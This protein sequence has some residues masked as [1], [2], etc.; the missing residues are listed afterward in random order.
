MKLHASVLGSSLHSTFSVGRSMFD[1]HLLPIGFRVQG[2][3]RFQV[4]GF[5]CQSGCFADSSHGTPL[6]SR[7]SLIGCAARHVSRLSVACHGVAIPHYRGTGSLLAATHP[8]NPK[9]AA[10]PQPIGAVSAMMRLAALWARG[11]AYE[12]H[13]AFSPPRRHG[14]DHGNGW[15]LA[16][17]AFFISVKL[18]ENPW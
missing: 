15:L 17:D 9:R 5:R 11:G 3:E 2:R 13:H 16:Q 6:G 7:C 4:S 1:V 12:T 8:R 18:R 10:Q 14:I